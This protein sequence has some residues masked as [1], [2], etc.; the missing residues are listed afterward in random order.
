MRRK[1][2][3]VSWGQIGGSK[4][5]AWELRGM[6]SIPKLFQLIAE[7]GVNA[8][9]RQITHFVGTPRPS[10]GFGVATKLVFVKLGAELR[11][12]KNSPLVREDPRIGASISSAARFKTLRYAFGDPEDY[13]LFWCRRDADGLA[14][15]R[16]PRRPTWRSEMKLSSER[17]KKHLV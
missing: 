5:N 12:N 13:A 4:G 11:L 17:S 16:E 8:L 15:K 7:D 2:L 10:S 9:P 3:L 14:L 1:S 6:L